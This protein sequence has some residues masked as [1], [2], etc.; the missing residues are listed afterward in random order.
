[1][2]LMEKET[3]W[4]HSLERWLLSQWL[5]SGEVRKKNRKYGERERVQN[6]KLYTHL[7]I[8]IIISSLTHSFVRSFVRS[9]WFK[10]MIG[11]SI[12]MTGTQQANLYDGER[13]SPS[14]LIKRRCI[15][16]TH[17]EHKSDSHFV[18]ILFPSVPFAV[19]PELKISPIPLVASLLFSYSIAADGWNANS[20]RYMQNDYQTRWK[21]TEKWKKTHRNHKQTKQ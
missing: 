2:Q 17:N 4:S 6:A 9:R 16:C 12:K 10:I 8:I 11:H 1:M 20:M 18:Y 7:S 14:D 19:E 21:H 5:R 3:E 15:S 13:K